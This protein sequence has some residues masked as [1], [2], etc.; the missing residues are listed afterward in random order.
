VPSA[1]ARRIEHPHPI[2]THGRGVTAASEHTVTVGA[3]TTSTLTFVI[4][5]STHSQSE[6]VGIYHDLAE[7]HAALLTQK[8][9]HYRSIINRARI[10]I[11]DPR[12]EELYSWVRIN[13]EWLVRDVP[14]VGRGLSGGFMEYPWWFGTVMAR[15]RK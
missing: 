7:H 9:A 1:D 10:R 5:G 13:M 8:V 11:P 15:Y 4:S 12:L 3:H 14:G 6:A 2:Q